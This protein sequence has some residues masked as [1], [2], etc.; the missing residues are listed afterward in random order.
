MKRIFKAYGDLLS[1][2]AILRPNELYN[3]LLLTSFLKLASTRQK[4]EPI[5]TGAVIP[6]I[7]LKDFRKLKL[8]LPPK[9][10]QDMALEVVEPIYKKCWVNIE[11]IRTLEKLRDTLLPKLMS[12]DVQVRM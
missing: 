6:R 1:S 2:I 3:S 12:G 7:V 9:Y 5:V 8:P 4:M 11:Q 10:I